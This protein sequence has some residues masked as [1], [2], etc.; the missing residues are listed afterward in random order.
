M[1]SVH[2]GGPS[3]LPGEEEVRQGEKRVEDRQA[4]VLILPFPLH[5]RGVLG[6]SLHLR[7]SQFSH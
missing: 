1:R 4:Y 2:P 7:G 3:R 6:K 5:G